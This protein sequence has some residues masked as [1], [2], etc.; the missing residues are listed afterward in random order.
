MELVF[1]LT[2]KCN[3]QCRYCYQGEKSD[4]TMTFETAKVS[5]DKAVQNNELV[6][7]S[8]FGGEP[9]LNKQLLYDIVN[10]CEK[11]KKQTKHQ[12][13][14]SITTNG[15]LADYEFVK[16]CKKNKILVGISIDGN[17]ESHDLNRMTK[18]G[19]STYEKTLDC[20]K[21][22]LKEKVNT[23][24]L[25][26]ICTNNVK[27]VAENVEY[28]IRFGFKEIT[29]N[30]NYNDSWNDDSLKVL[31]EQ[32]KQIEDIYMRELKSGNHVKIY[33][34]DKKINLLINENA[35]CNENCNRDRTC[36]D[37]DGKYYPCIQFVGKEKYCI[38]N[39][40][41]GENRKKR[42]EL[43]KERVTSKTP[44]EDCKLKRLCGFGCGC[45]RM[46]ATGDIK[47]VSPLVCETEKIYIYTANDLLGRI[48]EENEFVKFTWLKQ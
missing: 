10:Y 28:L 15:T 7:V 38:G 2:N 8:F 42:L 17:K 12:I 27:K 29:C 30:F 23:M 46:S 24:A 39:T 4:K 48:N 16:F 33:P 45:I 43:I 13:L 19:S 32:Y 22:C 36:V 5:I 14:Y 25:P 21:M 37:S 26:V 1:Y 34:I 40:L 11:L 20:A 3:M 44:C 31:K 35:F 47:E 9:L 41:D 6:T 18:D